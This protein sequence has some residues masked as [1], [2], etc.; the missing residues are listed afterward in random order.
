LSPARGLQARHRFL[1]QTSGLD[2]CP[3]H[4]SWNPRRNRCQ[5]S[6]G[7]RCPRLLGADGIDRQVNG[8]SNAASGRNLARHRR[9]SGHHYQ[10]NSDEYEARVFSGFRDVLHSVQGGRS[11]GRNGFAGSGR[12][13]QQDPP[14]R[15]R[16]G[17]KYQ[18]RQR[19]AEIAAGVNIPS[20][21]R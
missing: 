5:S 9:D 11:S 6:R 14:R 4:C 15:D 8:E 2:P 7:G 13:R 1:G 19:I 10:H 3:S 17:A 21:V 20:L 18:D 16:H 12:R